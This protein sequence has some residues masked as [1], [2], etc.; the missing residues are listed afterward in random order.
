[1]KI[2][3]KSDDGK[4]FDTQEECQKHE[5]KSAIRSQLTK[6]AEQYEYYCDDAGF[7]IMGADD[8]AKMIIDNIDLIISI[9]KKD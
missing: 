7:T 5:D 4:E 2:I 9:V 6:I 1:M 3:Y 8:C